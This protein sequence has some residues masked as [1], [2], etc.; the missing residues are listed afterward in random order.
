[1]CADREDGRV[2]HDVIFTWRTVFEQAS[3]GTQLF[4]DS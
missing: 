4:A 1:M 2:C 3:H